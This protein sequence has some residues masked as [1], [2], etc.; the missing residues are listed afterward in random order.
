M[1]FNSLIKIC[2]IVIFLCLYNNNIQAQYVYGHNTDLTNVISP[3][4]TPSELGKYAEIPVGLYTGI[5]SISIPLYQITENGHHVD[6]SLSYYA[7]GI[8]VQQRA[9]W[10]GLGWSLN[11]GGVITRCIRGLADDTDTIYE[12]GSI[13]WPQGK[14][15]YVFGHAL[16][17]Y[18]DRESDEYFFNFN[19][20]TGSFYFDDNNN[21]VVTDGSK[22]KIEVGPIIAGDGISEFTITTDDG[23]KYTFGDRELTTSLP[24]TP[25]IYDFPFYTMLDGENPW[26]GIRLSW[27][28]NISSWYLSKIE[29]PNS[30]NK[31]EFSYDTCKY[32][33][34]E[35]EKEMK[36]EG[37]S[38]G[39][40]VCESHPHYGEYLFY[41]YSCDLV[42]G[43]YLSEIKWTEGK[44]TF[45]CSSE[46]RQDILK[47]NRIDYGYNLYGDEKY[48]SQISITDKNN[49]LIKRF[50]L[51][52]DYFLATGYNNVH[53]AYS[54]WAE[55]SIDLA[56]L[57]KRLKLT[58][59][60]EH[61]G[62]SIKPPYLFEYKENETL[63]YRY[64]PECD[65]WGFYNANGASD[66]IPTTYIYTDLINDS[67]A[68]SNSLFQSI[69]LPIPMPNLGAVTILSGADR[70]A[71]NGDQSQAYMLK[72]ITYPTGG[73]DYFTYEPNKFRIYDSGFSNG[74]IEMTGGGIRIKQIDTYDPVSTQTKTRTFSYLD[75]DSI[76]SGR[77]INFPTFVRQHQTGDPLLNYNILR[78][79][80]SMNNL[81]TTEG[82]YVGYKNVT[83]HYSSNGRDE[84][85]Y[86][87]PA[88]F[89]VKQDCW[90]DT[91]GQ[92]IYTRSKQ[93]LYYYYDN[94]SYP[95][96]GYY[97]FCPSL[98]NPNYDWNRGQVLKQVT[99]NQ[100]SQKVKEVINSYNIGAY[101]KSTATMHIV[102]VTQICD[103]DGSPYGANMTYTT[104]LFNDYTLLSGWKY[105][106]K[107]DVYLFDPADENKFVKETTIFDYSN[108]IYKQLSKI[109]KTG[110][111]RSVLTT[112]ITYP[113]DYTVKPVAIQSLMNKYI[114]SVP[115]EVIQY[116]NDGGTNNRCVK[117]DINI[118]DGNGQ[119]LEKWS[120]ENQNSLAGLSYSKNLTSSSSFNFDSRYKKQESFQYD[121]S[122]NIIGAQK[123][124]NTIITYLWGYNKTLPVAEVKNASIDKVGYTSFESSQDLGGWSCSGNIVNGSAAKTGR[125]YF[126]MLGINSIT[127]NIVA[128]TYYIEYWVK[129]AISVT[130]N[131]GTVTNLVT[132][133][134]DANGWIYYKKKITA[135][136]STTL[137]LLG[138]TYIDEL[139][140]YPVGAQMTTYTYDPLI[141]M[142][143]S[144]D[145]NN[146]T[147][148]YEY[149]G[150][151]RLKRILDQDK[152]VLKQY[153][154][155]YQNQ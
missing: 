39:Y 40:T 21:P 46:T 84:Y 12:Q 48:L 125:S 75:A 92:Y 82:S 128:G 26:A 98:P 138:S 112:E 59:I 107:Q 74:F 130:V 17:N 19:G 101:S 136:S 41:P 141:G 54:P 151:G 9:S 66:L 88:A 58:S 105:L 119:L 137:N 13:F 43:L 114:T 117:G 122:G 90:D 47:T 69:Y 16:Y 87:F 23:I 78:S 28:T 124:D 147:T 95:A 113:Y 15:T 10:V 60:T 134:A 127:R 29:Y 140:L 72:K 115:V 102:T 2:F 20:Y 80:N 55:D 116:K 104:Q 62:S 25:D 49:K 18:I 76:C 148:Y 5:P 77:I 45:T 61:S 86:D 143:S 79:S 34:L 120:T 100:D 67:A 52:Y 27:Y 65:F 11:A 146:V 22:L 93:K 153:E 94:P 30:S 133:S 32:S 91:A 118:F 83:V 81:G 50:D 89:G 37:W 110:S 4:P 57:Y 135:T 3:P 155:H 142:T 56:P 31:V 68:L 36:Y 70:N 154:Y 126:E 14:L 53:Y 152:K 85:E 129:S 121:T 139:R 51:G 132:S 131:N 96:G 38:A 106:N 33:Y 73:Y 109:Q 24:M 149:D 97:D 1:R 103:D 144:T 6:I 108:K 71:K 123:K 7:S 64:S 8:K 63:P 150:L 44:I 42:K 99:Y 111:N 35:R 145:A